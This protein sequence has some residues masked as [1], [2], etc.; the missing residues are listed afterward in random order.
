MKPC[1]ALGHC[2][3]YDPDGLFGRGI[4]ASGVCHAGIKYD[5]VRLAA[6]IRGHGLPITLPC[7]AASRD[8]ADTCAHR[9]WP[10]DEQVR[11]AELETERA[12]EAVDKGLCPECGTAMVRADTSGGGYTARCPKGCGTSV[13][14]CGRRR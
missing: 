12:L 10:T 9:V 6:P 8:H 2:I 13:I 14:A 1:H 7:F 4:A 5:S 3:H 11:E